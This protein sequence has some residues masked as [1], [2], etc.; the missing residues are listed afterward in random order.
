MASRDDTMQDT[1]GGITVE[2]VKHPVG[3]AEQSEKNPGI[4]AEDRA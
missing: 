4:L 1:T 3:S 2:D